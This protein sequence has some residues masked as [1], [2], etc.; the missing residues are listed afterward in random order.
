MELILQ[1]LDAGQGGADDD[2]AGLQNGEPT[3]VADATLAAGSRWDATVV[4]TAP[5]GAEVARQRFVFALDAEGISEGRATP[6]L[7][8]GLVAAALL[9]I[10][11]IVGVGYT[12]VGGTLPR[13][14]SDA[15][16]PA[17]VG[18]RRGV[19]LG[20]AAIVLAGPRDPA[21]DLPVDVARVPA[22]GA[23]TI[24]LVVGIQLVVIAALLGGLARYVGG[25]RPGMARVADRC[26]AAIGGLVLVVAAALGPE[27]R[28]TAAQPD[29]E[30]GH[31]GRRRGGPLP[32]ELRALPRRRRPGR[33]S[34]AG[35]TQVPA[36]QPAERSPPPALR[37]RHLHL[38]QRR[39]AR[40]DAGLVGGASRYGPLEP[41]ELPRSI[42]GR[43]PSPS[44]A[45]RAPAADG[46]PAAAGIGFAG[47]VGLA[48]LGW[49]A[50]GPAQLPGR[51]PARPGRRVEP[52]TCRRDATSALR[53]G[54]ATDPSR[55]TA[56]LD[57]ARP[58]TLSS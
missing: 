42:D 47:V 44:P 34:D 16:R 35:T 12:V 11:G 37:R 24:G 27:A 52:L 51:C 22:G 25:R 54:A 13:T 46:P 3:F 40:W 4:V 15:G 56:R 57:R 9:L 23:I 39:P 19:A 33:G 20:F 49:L 7:D 58:C 10:L 6:P 43:G 1:R 38:D 18:Q 53:G 28:A 31:V 50:V 14:P 21:R 41:G 45:S 29:P 26:R 32:G 17:M 8:P 36:G 5:G 30:H 2:A 55:P 48:L